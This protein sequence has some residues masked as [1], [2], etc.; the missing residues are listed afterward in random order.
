MTARYADYEKSVRQSLWGWADRRHRGELD[1]GHR[2][3]RPPVLAVGHALK[4][5]LV[6]DDVARARRIREAASQIRWHPWFRS[7]TSSQ[8]LTCSVFGAIH[9]FGRLD[10]SAPCPSCFWA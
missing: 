10:T 4:N 6:P 1:G 2:E 8:A 3:N 9:A 7:L 5:V